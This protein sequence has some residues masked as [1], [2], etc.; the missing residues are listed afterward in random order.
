MGEPAATN[1]GPLNVR[2]LDDELALLRLLFSA[3]G[4]E[5]QVPYSVLHG[6]LDEG[7]DG[8]GRPRDGEVGGIA[9]VRRRNAIERGV[10]DALIVPVE[11]RIRLPR[12]VAYC[13]TLL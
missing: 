8:V 4:Q 7:A 9:D 11:R 3:T 10:P 5:N 6:S 13:V 12:S 1:D 2:T